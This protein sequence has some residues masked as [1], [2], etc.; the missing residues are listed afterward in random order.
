[1]S[2]THDALGAHSNHILELACMHVELIL[3][4]KKLNKASKY[5]SKY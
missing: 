3:E 2:M 5:A 4:L 1:M